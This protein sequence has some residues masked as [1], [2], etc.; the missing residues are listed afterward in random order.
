[1]TLLDP[2]LQTPLLVLTSPSRNTANGGRR[3]LQRS[4]RSSRNLFTGAAAVAA[5]VS[6]VVLVAVFAVC[7][8]RQHRQ[9]VQA[10]ERRR[11][12]YTEDDSDEVSFILEQCLDLQEEHGF[13]LPL[14]ERVDE[15]EAKE[16][17]V[18]MLHASAAAFQERRALA[19]SQSVQYASRFAQSGVPENVQ[20]TPRGLLRTTVWGGPSGATV[21]P[22]AGP[23]PEGVVSFSPEEDPYADVVFAPQQRR[24]HVPSQSLQF[25]DRSAL[26][27]ASQGMQMPTPQRPRTA[28]SGGPS[29]AAVAP[30]AGPTTEGVVSFSPLEDPYGDV[31]FASQQR[32]AQA[33]SQGQQLEDPVAPYGA[34]QSMYMPHPQQS[35]TAV[36][37]GRSGAKVAPVGGRTAEGV[38]SFYS[39]EDP[40]RDV[41]FVPRRSRAHVSSQRVQYEGRFGRSGASQSMYMAPAQLPPT[42]VWGR[43]SGAAVAPV[44]GRT[45]EDVVSFYSEDDPYVDIVS[46]SHQRRAH[47][48]S[49]MVQFEDHFAQSG[50]PPNM[51]MPTAQLPRTAVWGGPSGAEAAA[52]A[53]LTPEGV[54]SFSPEENPDGHTAFA[55]QAH[56]SASYGGAETGAAAV[57]ATV[58]DGGDTSSEG[59][60]YASATQ[61]AGWTSGSPEVASAAALSPDAWLAD[62]P[63]LEFTPVVQQG[64]EATNSSL[65]AA[66]D[67]RAS[68]LV[69]WPPTSS[70]PM[71]GKQQLEAAFAAATGVPG[72]ATSVQRKRYSEGNRG[73]CIGN[74]DLAAHPFVRLPT[75]SPQDVRSCFRPEYALTLKLNILSPMDSFMEMRR[76]FAK[77][78]LTAEEVDMLMF[79]A[80]SLANYAKDKLTRQF[81]RRKSSYIFRKL[82]TLFMVFDNLVCT[83]H[84]LGDKM[85]ASSWWGEFASKFETDFIF[86]NAGFS[87]KTRMLSRLVN[88]LS[89]A[90]SIYK[91][92]NRPP[93][94]EVIALKRRVLTQKCKGSQL[95]HPLWKLWLQDDDE[96]LRS[97]G[98]SRRRPYDNHIHGESTTSETS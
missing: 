14:S 48:A 20:I 21:A 86:P 40:K 3:L 32:R 88:R 84:I 13:H 16:G 67:M 93:L 65:V 90:L 11:L 47:V 43:P 25:E 39:A 85:L 23:T 7:Q 61:L 71:N 55:L 89:A 45:A 91:K 6:L 60:G 9:L 94:A 81:Q 50:A 62:L 96:F 70:K 41:A 44:V 56:T 79:E 64:T 36:W 97:R 51:Y 63:T 66:G 77:P 74:Q 12:S 28:V 80:E 72:P 57:P 49:D 15:R 2:Q 92:G 29:G 78:S 73:G 8:A 68:S 69:H 83:I 54:E 98:C 18:A 33:P 34:P 87:T 37:R 38:A 17:I 95:M 53:G 10:A 4:P 75:V 46:T 31:A 27:G 26:Y 58:D 42:A 59:G 1:M 19:S 5:V 52:V 76:L 35:R 22:A 30:V 24:A 82:S